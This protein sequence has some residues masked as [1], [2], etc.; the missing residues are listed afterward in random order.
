MNGD[1]DVFAL[2]EIEEASSCLEGDG[3]CDDC[4][5][6]EFAEDTSVEVTDEK[7]D[8]EETEEAE[9]C[10]GEGSEESSIDE[11]EEYERLIKTRFK[12]LFRE[13]TQRLINKRFK[14]YKALEEK[15]RV[16]EAEAQKFAEIDSLLTAERERAVAETEERMNRQFKA[17]RS[18][19]KENAVAPRVSPP[20]LDVSRLTKSERASLASR[21]LKG[22][23]IHL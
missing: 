22:E 15:V 18:R 21:A 8:V 11:R 7:I 16:L 2:N 12:E 1:G 10:E 19:A 23:K 5:R 13:D 17:M 4:G 9:A 3:E 6:D 14:K 20:P